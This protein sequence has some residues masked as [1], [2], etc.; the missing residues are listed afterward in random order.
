MPA[1]GHKEKEKRNVQSDEGSISNESAKPP[2]LKERDT[3]Q[4]TITA[5]FGKTPKKVPKGSVQPKEKDKEKEKGKTSVGMA[6]PETN[7]MIPRKSSRRAPNISALQQQSIT[8][9]DDQKP[10]EKPILAEAL[11]QQKQKE[12]KGNFSKNDDLVKKKIES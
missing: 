7:Q 1:T 3:N 4:P 8:K 6:P 11:Q 10:F 2:L 12:Q 9:D 5:F